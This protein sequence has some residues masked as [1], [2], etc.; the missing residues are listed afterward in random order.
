MDKKNPYKGTKIFVTKPILPD[1][2]RY[3]WQLRKIWTSSILTNGGPISK[4]LVY[5]LEQWLGVKDL[6]L[7]CNGTIALD[8]ALSAISIRNKTEVITTPY[9]FVASSNAIIRNGLTAVFVDIEADSYNICP[10]K[11]EQAI[12]EKTAAILGVHVYGT[13]C[14]VLE[15]EDIGRQYGIPVIYDGAHAFGSRLEGKSLLGYGD[16]STCSF[17]A[18]K[19]F[20][21]GEGG[22]IV[23]SHD[24]IPRLERIINFGF[25]NENDISEIGTNAKMSEFAAAVGVVNLKVTGEA[26]RKREVVYKWYEKYLNSQVLPYTIRK[27]HSCNDITWNYS[28]MPIR[29]N[30]RQGAEIRD[31]IYESLKSIGVFSRKYFYPLITE[32]TAYINNTDTWM[33]KGT[34][35]NARQAT[36]E[37]LCLPIYP[38]LHERDVKRIAAIVN[39]HAMFLDQS[40]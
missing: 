10:K 38:G 20:N 21:T 35:E 13:P 5:G 7:V 11:I 30:G 8:A 2:F 31:R 6:R 33:Q 22:C 17:H 32:T 24:T 1:F 19:V 15:I 25:C 12:T 37:T 34:L 18:T 23:G 27:A 9:S 4:E 14:Q 39:E 40:G 16:L 29:L 26:I 3:I 28:Y 36:L